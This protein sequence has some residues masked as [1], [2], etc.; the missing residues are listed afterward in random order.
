MV[1]NL[2]Q[3]TTAFDDRPVMAPVECFAVLPGD[4]RTLIVLALVAITWAVALGVFL[5]YEPKSPSI[6][7]PTSPSEPLF[8][9]A[10]GLNRYVTGAPHPSPAPVDS[11]GLRRAHLA[12]LLSLAS[13]A[14]VGFALRNRWN[15]RL[16]RIV[17]SAAAIVVMAA[18]ALL[19]EAGSLVVQH[20]TTV[21]RLGGVCGLAVLFLL[22][23]YRKRRWIQ[24]PALAACAGLIVLFAVPGRR[25]TLTYTS[26]WDLTEIRMEHWVYVV[27]HADRLLHGARLHDGATPSYGQLATLVNVA[28]QKLLGEFTMRDHLAFIVG[29]QTLV[30]LALMRAYYFLSRGVWLLCWPALVIAGCNFWIV[31][32]LEPNHSAWRYC[33]L[34]LVPW[35]LTWLAA[36]PVRF[37]ALGAG[38]TSCLAIIHNVETGVAAAAGCLAFVAF[39]SRHLAAGQIAVVAART[40]AGFAAGLLCWVMVCLVTLG[41]APDFVAA[42]RQ[43][44][45]FRLM[46]SSGVAAA[47]PTAIDPLALI[48]LGT[49]CFTLIYRVLDWR[50]SPMPAHAVQFGVAAATLVWFAYYANRPHREYLF[51]FFPLLGCLVIDP[52][53]LVSAGLRGRLPFTATVCAAAMISWVIVPVVKQQCVLQYWLLPPA[54]ENFVQDQHLKYIPRLGAY[55]PDDARTDAILHRAEYLKSRASPGLAFFSVDCYPIAKLARCWPRLSVAD[56]FWECLHV[57]Q[58]AAA[59]SAIEDGQIDE[60]LLDPQDWLKSATCHFPVC[61]GQRR[62]LLVLRD[63]IAREFDFVGAEGGWEVWRRRGSL[64]SH[65]TDGSRPTRNSLS[66]SNP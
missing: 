66:T 48:I 37:A 31:T 30:M 1:D 3:E 26:D 9:E 32:W 34:W 20:A 8:D 59:W 11:R 2:R 6:E 40:C 25:L 49:S 63:R 58:F 57:R 19:P 55:F 45:L 10:T 17:F 52:L 65:K 36:A 18:L 41:R 44:A 39:R 62:Y 16:G 47:L 35:I 51:G 21:Q 23:R 60:I 42:L 27:S 46:S 13:V 29:L 61:A 12:L 24:W 14:A 56:I 50:R 54:P 28:L 4:R 33:V 43:A 15:S 7:F 22:A 5:S 64:V 53:R 38:L